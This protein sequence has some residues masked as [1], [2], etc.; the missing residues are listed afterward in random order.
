MTRLWKNGYMDFQG[1]PGISH[2]SCYAGAR[3][4][5]FYLIL[6]PLI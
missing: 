6:W 5:H 4:A 1:P 2:L 3:Q